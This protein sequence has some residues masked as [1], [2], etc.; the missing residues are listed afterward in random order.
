M[1][2]SE[3]KEL[4]EQDQTYSKASR[5]QEITKIRA[6]LKEI[7]TQKSFTQINESRSYFFF[8]KK[9][10][11]DISQARLIKNNTG[12]NQIDTVKMIKGI[13]TLSPQKYK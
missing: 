2:S 4:G 1:F 3:L 7:E 12:K 6:K 9:N 10:K 8:L 11:L 13:L 5:T